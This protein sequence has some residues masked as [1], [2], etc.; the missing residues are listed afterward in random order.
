[1]RTCYERA[2]KVLRTSCESAATVLELLRKLPTLR[3]PSKP[4]EE[5]ITSAGPKRSA[6]STAQE[7][8]PPPEENCHCDRAATAHT[9]EA[10]ERNTRE[11]HTREAHVRSTR[12]GISTRDESRPRG[13]DEHTTE[14]TEEST[15]ERHTWG[16]QHT[17]EAYAREAHE[18][19][20]QEKHT[21]EDERTRGA[22]RE[23]DAQEKH[24]HEKITRG[25]HDTQAALSWWHFSTKKWSCLFL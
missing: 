12:G 16:D 18:R 22:K 3:P 9:R 7:F 2:A 6:L 17:R 11:K 20:T 19:A 24:T 1:L 10:H 13:G 14:A 23:R 15:R 8:M 5:R 4:T 25:K 21:W